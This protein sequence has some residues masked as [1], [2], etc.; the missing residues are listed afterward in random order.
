NQETFVPVI[1]VMKVNGI[2][3][4]IK[5]SNSL[6]YGLCA[7]V[8][9]KNKSKTRKMASQL[10]A[11]TICIN[12]TP[13]SRAEFPWGGRKQSGLGRMLSTQGINEYL[14]TKVIND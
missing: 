10:Q 9:S 8:Y 14:E 2:K 13:K 5:F 11:G 12:C 7:S 6:S 1:E 4:A 3:Q